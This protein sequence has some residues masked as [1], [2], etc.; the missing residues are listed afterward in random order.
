[1]DAPGTVIVDGVLT[2]LGESLILSASSGGSLVVNGAMQFVA[3]E[4][5][6]WSFGSGATLESHI[7]HGEIAD[8]MD[9]L[10]GLSLT[11]TLGS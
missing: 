6:E 1:M 2:M 11:Q 4:K 7:D 8:A 9:K 10:S 5:Q 3:L